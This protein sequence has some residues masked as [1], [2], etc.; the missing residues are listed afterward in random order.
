MNLFFFSRCDQ[1][2]AGEKETHIYDL[3][4]TAVACAECVARLSLTQAHSTP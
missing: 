4:M 3:L 1:A 2:A